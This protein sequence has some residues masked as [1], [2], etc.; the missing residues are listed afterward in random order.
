MATLQ[1]LNPHG[2]ETDL[3]TIIELVDRLLDEIGTIGPIGYDGET[4]DGE[5]EHYTMYED[6]DATKAYQEIAKRLKTLRAKMT[7]PPPLPTV[8]LDSHTL[9]P[10]TG[11]LSADGFFDDE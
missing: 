11:T 10:I 5:T 4:W 6:E 3:V 7:T 1:D 8:K 2:T 9:D